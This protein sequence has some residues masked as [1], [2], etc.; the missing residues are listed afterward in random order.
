M[1]RPDELK[2]DERGLLPC[3]V[4]DAAT[5]EV[6]M[7]AWQ[8]REALEQTIASGRATFFSRSRGEIWVKGAT[9]GNVQAVREV[10]ADCD[11]DAVLVRV[12]PAGPACHTG[13]RSCFFEPVAGSPVA[14]ESAAE[15]LARL[16]QVIGTRKKDAPPGS[17][18]A[19]LFAD[20][21]LR[22]KKIGEEATELVMASMRGEKQ[23][24]AAEAADVVYHLL[25]LL[26]SHGIGLEQLADELRSREGAQR[27][28]R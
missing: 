15:T 8:S 13:A 24:I 5:G 9:S 23:N 20:A 14:G 25:V 21:N 7:L 3:I 17:Y 18:T 28:P 12:I 1:V 11:R 19:K 26:Q 4:Q 16:E 6:L 10:R 27:N 2:Y 22:H